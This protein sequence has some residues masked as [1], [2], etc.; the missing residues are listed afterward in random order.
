MENFQEDREGPEVLTEHELWP[1]SQDPDASQDRTL[2]HSLRWEKK[3]GNSLNLIFILSYRFILVYL[4]K[5]S[6]VFSLTLSIVE[7]KIQM[8]CCFPLF[9]NEWEGRIF[10]PFLGLKHLHKGKTR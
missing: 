5:A 6:N 10:S 9:Y 2:A 7:T 1:A 4:P 8:I 3:S